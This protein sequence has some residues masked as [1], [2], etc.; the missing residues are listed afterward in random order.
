MSNLTTFNPAQLPA[1][2][3]NTELS[4][5]TKALM[6]NSS[7]F[8]LS[9]K[10]NVFRLL[11]NG[12]EY[13]KI[14]DRSL[15]IVVVSAAPKVTR[16]FYMAQYDDGAEPAAPDCTSSD[17]E[18]PDKRSLHKQAERCADCPQNA[19][20]SGQGDSRACRF[21]QALAVVLANDIGGNVLKLQVPAASIFGKGEGSNVPLREYVTQLA[22]IPVNIDTVVTKI[23][24]DLDSAAPK[25]FWA[26]A[27]YLTE[28]E[29][30]TAQKQGKS[31][32]ARRAVEFTVFEQDASAKKPTIAGEPPKSAQT[33]PQTPAP[34]PTPAPPPE[35]QETEE[36]REL[37]EFREFQAMK[38]AAAEKAAGKGTTKPRTKKEEP[39]AP[40]PAAEVAEPTVRDSGASAAPAPGRANLASVLAKWDKP[41]DGGTDD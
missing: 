5:A 20:G 4:D 32:A 22:Q 15:E 13:A 25:L 31:E 21:N 7:G 11:S 12:K 38:K 9:I 1:H 14:P 35:P 18:V 17:G 10:G 26:P 24:F 33:G 41:E 37:R 39:V 16:T 3:R 6:G 34:A 36:E 27:R 30:A 2:L 40:P 19:K 29:Y 28:D 8:R 23:S